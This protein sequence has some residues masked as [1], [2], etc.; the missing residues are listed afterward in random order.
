MSR[1]VHLCLALLLA[2]PASFAATKD[3][4]EQPTFYRDVL[5]VLQENCQTCHRDGGQKLGG[6]V[7]PM[8]LMSYEDVRP[9]AKSIAK[10]VEARTMPPWHASAEQNGVF[11]NQR[12]LEGT[13]IET[14]VRWARMR[15]TAAL[16][17]P[18]KVDPSRV[19]S[20]HRA[21]RL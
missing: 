21:A 14:L 19:R 2:A 12:T 8:A 9:W 18:K 10:Q 17:L 5:P 20:R 13:E 3:L 16:P 6:Q 1:S 4:I 15:G 11:H 7:A